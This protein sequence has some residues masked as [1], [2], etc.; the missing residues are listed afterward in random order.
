MAATIKC[1]SPAMM[2]LDKLMRKNSLYFERVAPML[3]KIR[4]PSADAPSWDNS[5]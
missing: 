5:C 4:A 3:V 1:G 2:V